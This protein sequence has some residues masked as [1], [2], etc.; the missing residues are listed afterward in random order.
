MENKQT[1]KNL[2]KAIIYIYKLK[3]IVTISYTLLYILVPL[4][5]MI[6][7]TING[8]FLDSVAK[9]IQQKT[10][11]TIK[12]FYI[13]D[14]FWYLSMSVLLWIITRVLNRS[15]EYLGTF[16]DNLYN[17]K[18]RSNIL[19][20]L[21]TE[22]LQE[23]EDMEFQNLLEFVR[24]YSADNILYAY[25]N[26]T[27]FLSQ[28]I[29]F[30]SALIIVIG[31]TGPSAI[32]LL[33]IALPEITNEYKW[34]ENFASFY[35]KTVE[36]TRRINYIENL[37]LNVR[38]FI[39]LKV[40]NLYSSFIKTFNSSGKKQNSGHN[41]RNLHSKIDK[42]FFSALDQ[43]LFRMYSVYLIAL[44]IT[45]NF[46]IGKFQ[47]MYNYA[48]TTYNSSY[49][50]LYQI[51]ILRKN[52]IYIDKYF[53]FINYKGF[54]DLSYG[55]A[56]LKKDINSIEMD[57]LDFKYQHEDVKALEDISFKINAGEKVAI[58][59]GDG[60]GKSTFMKI[61]CGLYEITSGDYRVN[62]LS[63]REL[64][65][66]ELKKEISIIN[67]VFNQYYIPLKQNITINGTGEFNLKRYK[68]VKRIAQVEKF[69]EKENL[70]ENQL[71]GKFFA[72]GREISPGYWQ[73]LAIAR[74]LYR[75]A[76]IY[77]MDE[78]FTYIDQY[79]RE[80]ILKNTM[81]FLKDKIVI[82]IS[83]DY[84]NLDLFDKAYELKNGH[85]EEYKDFK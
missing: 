33:F 76:S 30:F 7:I 35:N 36:R 21:A 15:H 61:L 44:A 82:Y 62:N 28:L 80:K 13:S 20:K 73:R 74:M 45:K 47:A 39:E 77:I 52:A 9:L 64:D 78:A 1:F 56:K 43:I 53:D 70:D 79:S 31:N 34:L 10:E 22:N 24:K 14:A 75:K 83:Q 41:K 11:F 46:T 25:K 4:V 5:E 3:P 6:S 32:I 8:K 29:R 38:S 58:I 17:R 18:I 57:D 16:V 67:Q 27:K 71:L 51:A 50:T 66:G 42:A 59:G 65:R 48:S 60:S 23:I 68:A 19:K 54:G 72:S 2:K 69:I 49:N 63:I 26:F 84:E 12:G 81:S 37:L 85:L 40:N 55:Q